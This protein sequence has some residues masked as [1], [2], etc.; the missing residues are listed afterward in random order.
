MDTFR[1]ASTVLAALELVPGEPW[2]LTEILRQ[3]IERAALLGSSSEGGPRQLTSYLRD[4]LDADHVAHWQRRLQQLAR[5]QGV[6][7]LVAGEPDYPAQLL[8]CWD[9]P[10]LLFVRGTLPEGIGVAIVGSRDA[11]AT[12]VKQATNVGAEVAAA[13][14]VVISGLA[15][16]IDAAA[17]RGALMADGQTVAVM[18]T[19]IEQIFPPENTDLAKE[20]TGSGALLSQFAPDAPRTGTTF[21]RRNR[22]IAGLASM[23]LIMEGRERSGSRHEA[24]Q[25]VSYGRPVL[26]WHPAMQQERWAH[27]LVSSGA[28]TFVSTPQ[29]VTKMMVCCE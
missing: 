29:E 1:L 9:A 24:E 14:L 13:G 10:P 4:N 23:S 11:S 7:P 16:G 12:A 5:S 19:G 17:H 28:A 25:A 21:L 27:D 26:L 2:D 8:G 22:V 18:G 6:R 3:P 20:I 15:A